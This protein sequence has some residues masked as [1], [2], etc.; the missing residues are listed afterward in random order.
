MN[1]EI[2]AGPTII[3][4]PRKRGFG[5]F[6]AILWSLLY[7]CI[8]QI[9]C[10]IC[11]GIPVFVAAQF[12]SSKPAEVKQEKV[13]SPNEVK[14]KSESSYS[15][16]DFK[17]PAMIWPTMIT[18][19]LSHLGGLGFGWLMLRASCG[20]GWK[21]EIALS[22]R[23]TWTHIAIVALGMPALLACSV[24]LDK[25]ISE[26]IPTLQGLLNWLGIK[27]PI[28]FPGISLMI[29]L[30][31]STPWPL[32]IFTVAVLPAINEEFW[33]RG[34]IAQG[35]S[36][37][38]ASWV[39]V[40]ITSFIFGCLHFDPQQGT[41]AM[42]LGLAIHYAYLKTRSLWIA[43]GIHF[44]NNA[45]AV[46]AVNEGLGMPLLEPLESVFK[47]KPLL[48]IVS[49][50]MFLLAIGYALHQTRSFIKSGVEGLVTWEPKNPNGVEVP[51]AGKLAT[52]EH[53]PISPL[54]AFLIM[55]GAF[56]FAIVMAWAA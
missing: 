33:C 3:E 16:F 43:M 52:V 12:L 34:F 23:P 13:E 32:A 41:G 35:L 21:R 30:F 42:I 24:V 47:V 29:E 28:E 48:F 36:Y 10:G 17:D 9:L 25:H 7:F 49:S 20:K 19:I 4:I 45:I 1:E 11:L 39:V 26:T 2:S 50:V 22:Q 31:K 15:K 6:V 14:E 40:A 55:I 56:A 53:E 44:V 51:P 18:L 38:Y 37:R 54:S 8:M 5:I 27:L 46:I